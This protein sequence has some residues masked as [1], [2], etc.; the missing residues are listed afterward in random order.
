[1]AV[2]DEVDALYA[3]D[4]DEFVEARQALVKRLRSAGD[5]ERAAEVAK[6]RRPTA[7][8]WAV[9]QLARRH[10]DD[11]AGLVELGQE[12]HRAHERLLAGGR[13]D[14]TVTS[15]RR[16]REAIADLVE[17]AAGILA[18]S[19]RAGDAHRDAIAATLDAASLDPDRAEDVVAGRL[20]KELDP[21]SGFGV[22]GGSGDDEELLW[23]VPEPSAPVRAPAS[24]TSGTKS[25]RAQAAV[26]KPAV[27]AGS[28]A[29]TDD[30]ATVGGGRRGP[31]RDS[32]PEGDAPAAAHGTTGDDRAAA[33]EGAEAERAE[34]AARAA[35]RAEEVRRRAVVAR[36]AATRARGL[37]DQAQD[38]ADQ[39]NGSASAWRTRWCGPGAPPPTPAGRPASCAMRPARPSAR[40]RRSRASSA[41]QEA[42]QGP[43]GGDHADDDHRHAPAEG[44]AGQ[45]AVLGLAWRAGEGQDIA[46]HQRPP[47]GEE[48]KGQEVFTEEHAPNLPARTYRADRARTAESEVSLKLG[49]VA[50]DRKGSPT[51]WGGRT[52]KA[53]YAYPLRRTPP[54]LPRRRTTRPPNRPGR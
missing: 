30:G 13:D 28:R 45:V 21:P 6:L 3:A 42:G 1:M 33:A 16:R 23:A 48:E 5:R 7:A 38:A 10:P 40:R 9:N 20:S 4:P 18:D 15:G 36:E 8:A 25:A 14:A 22:G 31:K 41:G 49:P 19:G 34:A 50:D 24:A 47:E 26:K 37:A 29:T 11:L 32:I 12:L 17:R 39:R 43:N 53:P 35:R 54:G 27:D 2:E 51:A 52:P 46:H 44:R